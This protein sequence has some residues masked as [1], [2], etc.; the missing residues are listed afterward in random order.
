MDVE[1]FFTNVP[2]TETIS[3]ITNIIFKDTGVF[4]GFN[5]KQFTILLCLAVQDNVFMLNNKLFKQVNG[6]AM[7][8][9]LSPLFANFFLGF[10]EQKYFTECN[11]VKPTFYVRYVN[12][13]F[14]FFNNK[15]HIEQFVAYLST[16]HK[17][18]K[19]TYEIENNFMLFF[20]GV[21]VLKTDTGFM[22]SIH[23]KQT[24]TGLGL[25]TN[26]F[27]VIYLIRLRKV[28]LLVYYFVFIL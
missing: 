1:F 20:I 16:W 12:D 25:D 7:G 19:F 26:F 4:N 14:I 28:H 9:P 22:S 3:I 8:S 24:H 18:L 5:K 2:V 17:N 13:T 10:L 21:N 11:N 23:Y 6:V 27:F 15:N